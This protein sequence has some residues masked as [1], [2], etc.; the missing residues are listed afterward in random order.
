MENEFI[1][2]KP[3]KNREEIRKEKRKMRKEKMENDGYSKNNHYHS[4]PQGAKNDDQKKNHQKQIHQ[5]EKKKEEK[6]KKERNEKM[7]KRIRERRMKKKTEE[8]KTDILKKKVLKPLILNED[9]PHFQSKFIKNQSQHFIQPGT[10]LSSSLH[11]NILF[12]SFSENIDIL[13]VINRFLHTTLQTRDTDALLKEK[14]RLYPTYTELIQCDWEKKFGIESFVAE[15]KKEKEIKGI[16]TKIFRLISQYPNDLD[17]Q[18]QLFE[19]IQSNVF[20]EESRKKYFEK[21]FQQSLPMRPEHINELNHAMTQY[22]NH[23]L[24]EDMIYHKRNNR[25]HPNIAFELMSVNKEDKNSFK[26]MVQDYIFPEKEKVFLCGSMTENC[27]IYKSV[28]LIH[29]PLSFTSFTTPLSSHHCHLP[30]QQYLQYIQEHKPSLSLPILLS[31]HKTKKYD[32]EKD[33][34]LTFVGVID[35]PY[36]VV[37][38]RKKSSFFLHTHQY[39]YLYLDKEKNQWYTFDSSGDVLENGMVFSDEVFQQYHLQSLYHYSK[40]VKPLYF[41]EYKENPKYIFV[42]FVEDLDKDSEELIPKK[43]EEFIKNS[44]SYYHLLER[45]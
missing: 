21:I 31:T 19:M 3:E 11:N 42:S 14:I 5:H 44:R 38:Y 1:L 23:L 33:S 26:K 30:I 2:T 22:Q 16:F 12:H 45:K 6:E 27:K 28:N 8:E 43:L 37:L 10:P 24:F 7:V 35:I 17:S 34:K 36:S 29:H 20:L 25:F 39:I 15:R 40:E 4:A 13:P 9:I 41:Y 18:K 32:V